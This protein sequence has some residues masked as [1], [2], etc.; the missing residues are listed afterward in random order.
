MRVLTKAEEAVFRD[1]FN[2]ISRVAVMYYSVEHIHEIKISYKKSTQEL[3]VAY[4]SLIENAGGLYKLSALFCEQNRISTT[5]KLVKKCFDE[6]IDPA[7]YI[8]Y[9]LLVKQKTNVSI[10]SYKDLQSKASV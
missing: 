6:G 10:V 9:G 2:C 3:P 5:K 8:F 7:S 4:R 1:A